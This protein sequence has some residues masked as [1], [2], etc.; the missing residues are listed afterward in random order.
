[1]AKVTHPAY[2]VDWRP[3]PDSEGNVNII[4]SCGIYAC[5][6]Q[7]RFSLSRLRRF[8]KR[9]RRDLGPTA[10]GDVDWIVQCQHYKQDL[11]LDRIF[12]WFPELLDRE[13]RRDFVHRGYHS[14][15]DRKDEWIP[16]LPWKHLLLLDHS[17]DYLHLREPLDNKT[18][19]CLIWQLSLDKLKIRPLSADNV[20]EYKLLNEL[21]KDVEA[22]QVAVQ[23]FQIVSDFGRKTSTNL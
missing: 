5:K 12:A 4:Y 9:A 13:F 15:I 16:L 18:V 10:S 7:S 11:L 17:L 20:S 1:M 8:S 6:G 2:K 14:A 21:V 19:R 3:A 23:C 22:A